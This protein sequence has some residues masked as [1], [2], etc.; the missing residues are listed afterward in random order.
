MYIVKPVNGSAGAGIKVVGPGEEVENEK[1]HLVCEY[2]P[3]P[4]LIEGKKYDLRIYVLITS[5]EPLRVYMYREG[6]IRLCSQKYSSDS[7]TLGK[8]SVHLTN[9]TVNKKNNKADA[10]TDESI[11]WT[12]T[13]V[14]RWMK[15]KGINIDIESRVKHLIVKTLIA[16]EPL[17]TRTYKQCTK[18]RNICHNL[19][20]FDVLLDSNLRPHIMEINIA[21]DYKADHALDVKIKTMLMVDTLNLVGLPIYDREAA[22]DEKRQ[23]KEYGK[24]SEAKIMK[25]R[26][27]PMVNGLYQY[28]KDSSLNKV[29]TEIS[30]KE[31]LT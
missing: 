18:Y 9:Y 1:G 4:H 21:P 10:G 13:R 29:L 20:G 31:P 15:D 19:V 7:K 30:K 28:T 2:I 25:G 12:L 23:E 26:A 22:E 16:F 3:N 27:P 17:M 11:K 8:K 24:S 5:F 6:L 14:Y